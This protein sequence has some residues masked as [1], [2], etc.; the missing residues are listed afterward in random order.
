MMVSGFGV[1]AKVATL[2]AIPRAFKRF[3]LE[4]SPFLSRHESI[5]I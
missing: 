4:H 2:K 1:S 3:R 5:S